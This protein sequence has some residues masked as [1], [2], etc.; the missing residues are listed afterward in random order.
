LVLRKL[1]VA[2]EERADKETSQ[3]ND[4]GN[5]GVLGR[6]GMIQSV[7]KEKSKAKG[8]R[9]GNLKREGK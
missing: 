4:T 2:S 1:S 3:N 9:T 7:T 5:H 8:K 6:T